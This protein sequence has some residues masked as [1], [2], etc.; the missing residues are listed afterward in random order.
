[1]QPLCKKSTLGYELLQS[2]KSVI[3]ALFAANVQNS[4][5]MLLFHFHPLIYVIKRQIKTDNCLLSGYFFIKHDNDS[6]QKAL[7]SSLNCCWIQF[8]V[9]QYFW[10]KKNVSKLLRDKSPIL[11]STRILAY[12]IAFVLDLIMQRTQS[13]PTRIKVGLTA[14]TR[15]NSRFLFYTRWSLSSKDVFWLY[16]Q[17]AEPALRLNSAAES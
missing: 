13:R 11:A 17:Q 2:F 4:H 10:I 3:S 5:A 15:P 8:I 16:F 12:L 6:V 1:M 7:M 14:L 9:S